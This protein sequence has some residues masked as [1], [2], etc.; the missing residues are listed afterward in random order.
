MRLAATLLA[1]A[2]CITLTSPA[3]QCAT[4]VQ[5]V[6]FES[7]GLRRAYYVFVPASVAPGTP[8]PVLVLLHGS[9]GTGSEITRY[10]TELARAQGLML[11]APNSKDGIYWRLKE[12]SPGFIRDAVESV[13]A[14]H[15]LDRRRVYLFGQ[16]GG[17]V[18]ALTLGMLESEYFAAVAVHAGSWREPANYDVLKLAQRKIPV[19]IFVGDSDPFFSVK[20]VRE[21]EDAMRGAGHPVSVTVL[22]RHQH[23][24]TPV[25]PQVTAAAWQFLKDTALSGEPRYIAF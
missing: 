14:A 18:Y 25:A 10:W 21:T 24:L 4:G 16:S 12:D 5:K 11:L 20:S 2:A 15:P 23:S 13:A 6:I 1:V 7:G 8:A 9:G 3:A 19:A 17:A 22:P